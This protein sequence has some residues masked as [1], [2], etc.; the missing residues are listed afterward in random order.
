[1]NRRTTPLVGLSADCKLLA[2]RA[3]HTLGD[4]YA[5]AVAEASGA[6][7]LVLPAMGA[8]VDVTAVLG[9]LDGIVLTG[10]PSNVHPT[11]YG[12]SPSAVA[13]PY[14]EARDG[15]TFALIEAALQ[16]AVPLFG[17]CRGFQEMNVALGGTLHA[18]LHEQPERDDHRARVSDDV[19]VRYGPA[20]PLQL[21]R[22][23]VLHAL[24]DTDEVVVNSLHH[25]GVDRLAERLRVEA[26]AADGTVEAVSVSDAAGFALAVQ[27][28]PEHRVLENPVSMALFG[29]FGDAAR[30][31][32]RRRG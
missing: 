8:H 27:W 11:R 20:H 23:G 17:I 18:C 31:R 30:E 14:D 15:L 12:Q 7:P 1:M 29:A 26:V 28:H 9:A 10:S 5:R 32:A 22:G 16:A 24:L 2:G 13:E 3:Y 19:D 4:K 25:Q 6:T 21:R